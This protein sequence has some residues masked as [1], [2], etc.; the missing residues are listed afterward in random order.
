MFD[1]GLTP[2]GVTYTN[3]VVSSI[4]ATPSAPV[5]TGNTVSLSEDALGQATLHYI[6]QTD[7]GSGGVTWANVPGALDQSNLTVTATWA[8]GTY[9]Y[10]VIVTNSVPSSGTSPIVAV[11]AYSVDSTA[12]LADLGNNVIPTPGVNDIA[13]TNAGVVKSFPGGLNYYFD[14]S[15]PPGETFT[16][17]GNAAGY[18]MTSLALQLSG[19]DAAQF[20]NGPG[21]PGQVFY[22][23]IY[24]VNSATTNATLYAKYTSELFSNILV[25]LTDTDWYQW[26]G[27]SLHLNPSSVY[28][29]TFGRDPSTG[30]GYGNLG[31]VAGGYAGGQVCLIPPYGGLMNL[32]TDSTQNG[33][34]DIGLSLATV[35]LSLSAQRVGG[36]LQVTYSGG[37]LLQASSLTGPWT[38]NSSPSPVTITPSAPKQFFRVL[39]NP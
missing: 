2:T 33:V 3:V 22:L 26:T 38:T 21:N 23:R 29:Y 4:V 7:N 18:T 14:N 32:G 9:N 34:F 16:T 15:Q 25:G 35:P 6:W 37:L 12:V 24:Q 13:Q 19:D 8:L 30:Y 17:L 1:I 39:R 20:T 11:T 36:N 27:F 28:A 31:N 5:V 10:R